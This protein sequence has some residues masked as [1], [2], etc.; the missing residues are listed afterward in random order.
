MKNNFISDIDYKKN[1]ELLFSD[2]ISNQPDSHDLW[3]ML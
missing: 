2:K 1:E 3:N